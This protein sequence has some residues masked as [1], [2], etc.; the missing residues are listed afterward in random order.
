MTGLARSTALLYCGRGGVADTEVE[1][2]QQ[3]FF[4]LHLACMNMHVPMR[5]CRRSKTKSG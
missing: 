5:M 1:V 4:A 3:F 2:L